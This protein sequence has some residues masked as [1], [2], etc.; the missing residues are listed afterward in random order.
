MAVK[1]RRTIYDHFECFQLEFYL[2][3][4]FNFIKLCGIALMRARFGCTVSAIFI[5]DN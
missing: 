4:L 5:T 2:E 3:N 1:P